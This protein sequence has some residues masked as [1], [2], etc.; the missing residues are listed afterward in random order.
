[1]SKLSLRV[2][3]SD[4]CSINFKRAVSRSTLTFSLANSSG[5][6]AIVGF[7]FGAFVTLVLVVEVVG[8][9]TWLWVN[10]GRGGGR[11]EMVGLRTRL[12]GSGVV[13]EEREDARLEMLGFRTGLVNE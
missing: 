5:D 4:S 10:L 13:E 3:I 8:A 11:L 6:V 2:L 12:E 9:V 1:M 7:N